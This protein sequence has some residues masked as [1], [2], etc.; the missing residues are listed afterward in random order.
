ML[1]DATAGASALE[2]AGTDLIKRGAELLE[3]ARR[4]RSTAPPANDNA[5]EWL[6]V[7]ASPLGKRK[8]LALARSGALESTKVGRKILVRR[9]SLETFLAAH[10]R[11]ADVADD[12]EDLFAAG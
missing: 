10:R 8:T 1:T 6:P 4:M 2:A 7:A 5:T 12:G 11:N 3:A 9:S